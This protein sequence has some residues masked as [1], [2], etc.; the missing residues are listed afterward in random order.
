M[1]AAVSG[2]VE[3]LVDQ[4]VFERLVATVG[5]PVGDVFPTGGKPRLLARLRGFNQA[6]R[7]TPWLVLVDLDRDAEC[8]PPF[9]RRHLRT[10]SRYMAFRVA[11]RAV[12]SWLLADRERVAAWLDVPLRR[13]PERPEALPD[14]KL[15]VV[16]LARRSHSRSVRDEM[17]P[18][19]GSGRAVGMLYTSRMIE[20]VQDEVDGWRPEIAARSSDSLDR[21]LRDLQRIVMRCGASGTS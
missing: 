20:F 11:V 7:H 2:A 3:G 13:V 18:R 19:D 16:N 17:V 1:W 4:A 21:C 8:A 5:A 9:R 15:E 14:P 10:P 6:A 12:E